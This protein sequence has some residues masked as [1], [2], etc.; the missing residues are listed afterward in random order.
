ILG[1]NGSIWRGFLE[2]DTS[3]L[4]AADTPASG[5]VLLHVKESFID[6][7]SWL[8]T[9]VDPDTLVNPLVVSDYGV[10]LNSVDS[11]GL[12]SVGRAGLWLMVPL[13]QDG[14]DLIVKGGVTRFGLRSNRDR[15]SIT[16][17]TSDEYAKLDGIYTDYPPRLIV[18]LAA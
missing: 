10:L 3:D 12:E 9:V 4:A 7:N 6:G 11:K 15:Y 5:F 1:F 2:F 14:L 8:L 16:G 13:A 17:E 18:Q